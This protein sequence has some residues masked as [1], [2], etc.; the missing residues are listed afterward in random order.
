MAGYKIFFKLS[1]EKDLRL[2][3]QKDLKKILQH[4][5]SLTQDPRPPGSEKLTGQE[6]YRVRQG[7]YRIL[8]SI[9]DDKL[10]IWVVKI[11]HRKE[12]YR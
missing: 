1:V 6:R 10:T 4:I 2:I 9:Q 11:G 3:P 7:R 8:Y 12:V 5:N